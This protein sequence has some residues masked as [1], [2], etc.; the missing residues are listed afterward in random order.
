MTVHSS[1]EAVRDTVL[2]AAPSRPLTTDLLLGVVSGVVTALLLWV[3]GRWWSASLIPWFEARI[4][5]GLQVDGEWELLEQIEESG[6]PKFEDREMLSIAQKA[7]RLTGTMTLTDRTGSS[8]RARGLAGEIRDRMVCV[9]MSADGR[10]EVSYHS[11]LAEVETDGRSM[12][13]IAVYYDLRTKRIE[14]AEVVYHR[15][16]V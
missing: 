9:T 16:A 4:Y 12:R 10:N 2:I 11:L 7:Q 8:I 1:L 15:R 6:E 3:A 14:S 5:K 13:G